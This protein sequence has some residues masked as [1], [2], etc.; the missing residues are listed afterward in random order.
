M[1]SR[2]DE[3]RQEIESTRED[4]GETIDEINDRVNP[5]RIVQ[6]KKENV[7]R[8]VHT[9][10]E[11]VM[12]TVGPE[13]VG[14]RIEGSPLAAGLIAFGIGAL[15]ASLL[16][17]DRS[18]REAAQALSEHAGPAVARVKEAG[19]EIGSHVGATAKE[20]S[21]HLGEHVKESVEHVKAEAQSSGETVKDES[22]RAADDVRRTRE[23]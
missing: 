19:A 6:R 14:D 15:A 16:P 2:A 9:V 4:L 7:Q 3:L 22:Q 21:Q 13:R 1:G 5:A 11:K 20:S 8:R 18:S 12:G 17:S 10:R 23:G